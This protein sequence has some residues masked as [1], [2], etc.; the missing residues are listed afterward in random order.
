MKARAETGYWQ[1]MPPMGYRFE[2]VQGHG[3]LLVRDEP[4]ASIIQQ[5]LEGYA[6]GHFASQAEIM[7]YFES[8]PAFPRD[9]YGEVRFRRVEDIL[10]Q[11]IYAG[12]LNFKKWG[13]FM[14]K[15]HHEGIIDLSVYQKIQNLIKQNSNAPS[16]VDVNND[17]PLRGFVKCGCCGH[18]MTAGW[19]KGRNKRYP[20]YFCQLRSCDEKRKNIRGEKI[21]G[22]FEALL[23][24]MAPSRDLFAMGFD[25]FEEL[26]NNREL[27]VE[28]QRGA[29]KAEITA[30]DKKLDQVMDRLIELDSPAMIQAYENQ[31][32]KLE[33]KKLKIEEKVRNCGRI[34]GDFKGVYQTAMEFLSNPCNLW[35][36]DDLTDK[37]LAVKA[38]I[39]RQFNL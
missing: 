28:N 22:E 14:I 33:V 39:W 2:K 27:M 26:W 31:V 30:V 5:A 24:T 4:I 23:Q 18:P 29:A 25:M 21:E 7:R 10:K 15:G 17:F 32:Q 20:Y 3:K 37:R 8:Q 11:P 36:S 16:R 35:L 13:M 34:D 38:Y 9:Q 19:S 6:S 12:H 1:H